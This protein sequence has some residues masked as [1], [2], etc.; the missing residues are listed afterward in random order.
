[1]S[2]CPPS[3]VYSHQYIPYL[4]FSLYT[5]LHEISSF[6]TMSEDAPVCDMPCTIICWESKMCR[7]TLSSVQT[8]TEVMWSEWCLNSVCIFTRSV[9]TVSGWSEKC[10]NSH[11]RCFN[12][13]CTFTIPVNGVQTVTRHV[14]TV[15][16]HLQNVYY[17]RGVWRLFEKSVE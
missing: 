9:R 15:F 16:G 14:W 17:Q 2:I 11:K 13:V 4:L 6:P 10:S 1:M 12:T 5:C 7:I 8:V 3:C